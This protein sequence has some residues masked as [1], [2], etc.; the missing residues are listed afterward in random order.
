MNAAPLEIIGAVLF[1]MALVHTFSTKLFERLSHTHPAHAGI[2]HFLGEVEVVF[3]LWATVLV[4]AM[5]VIDGKQAAVFADDDV[6]D[7]VADL[8]LVLVEDGGDVDAVLRE[9]RRARDRLTEQAAPT[10]AMLCWP[11]VRRILRISA[12]SD[13]VVAD[14]ALPELSERREIPPDLRRVDV[15]VLRDSCDE[16][17]C[18][19]SS[20]PAS[21]PAD[22][23]TD[24]PQRPPSGDLPHVL[25]ASSL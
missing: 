22:T 4:I 14:A 20:S 17:S 25:L 12:S 6:A 10:S 7:R 1:G 18:S 24:E 15:R 5:L 13:D 9:D 23:E 11:D 3:G 2:W 21:A 16:M 19:P 8:G